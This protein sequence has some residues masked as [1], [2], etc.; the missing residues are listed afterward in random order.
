MTTKLLFILCF[1]ILNFFQ[2]KAQ[3]FLEYRVT[4]QLTYKPDTT[5]FGM[6]KSETM[7]L[8]ANNE[9]SLFLSKGLALKDSISKNFDK[10]MIGTERWKEKYKS[11]K[12]DFKYRIFKDKAE[13]RL[14][15]GIKILEDRLYY[16]EPL[17][18]IKWEIK[19]ENKII[20]GYTAQ[21]ATTNFAGRK[22]IAWF[23]PEIPLSDGPYKFAGLPGLILELQ[24]IEENYVFSFKGFQELSNPLDYQIIPGNYK[25]VKKEELLNLI[26][27]YENDPIS[28]INNYVGEGGKIVRIGLEG[29]EKED[30]LKKHR[31]KLAKN[32]NPIELE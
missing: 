13:K 15:Y 14:G 17:T 21:K 29:K 3:N 31:A 27:T 6:T 32:N 22:Y 7:W 24:D 4:Y 30:Y 28:Y 5:D 20:S 19:P 9:S 2:T 8:F 26:E 12:T 18:Q 23:T 10:S 11:A 1:F 25:S 16:S